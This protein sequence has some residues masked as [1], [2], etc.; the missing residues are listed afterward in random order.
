VNPVTPKD[1]LRT[2]GRFFRRRP[3]WAPT[4][5]GGLLIVCALAFLGWLLVKSIHPFLAANEPV[6]GGVL[7]VEGWGTDYVLTAA[8]DQ[9][10]SH[11]YEK[12]CV[13][14]GPLEFG[15]PLAEYKTYAERGAAVL[16][17][18]GMSTNDVTA[19]P[20]AFVRQDRTYA[21]ARAL[22]AWLGTNQS[23]VARI[24]VVSGGPHA[25]RSRLLY[26]K[27]FGKGYEIG[28]MAVPDRSYDPAHWWRSS[29]G[30]RSVTDEAIAY[31]Y[32][33]LFFWPGES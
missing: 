20:A 8:R 29:Q 26:Q 21:A 17:Q 2:E 32:A 24:D 9:Y 18:L 11:K 25:R 31:I 10:R 5:R 30:F 14:G 12:L 13:T 27:A 3:V 16:L 19:V 4:W 28:I 22:K 6:F 7:A 15:A 33:R 1:E 23:S